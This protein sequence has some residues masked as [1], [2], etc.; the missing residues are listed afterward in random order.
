MARKTNKNSETEKYCIHLT[1]PPKKG[2]IY[3]FDTNN[4]YRCDITEKFCIAKYD[5]SREFHDS[6]SMWGY[7]Y[8]CI[9]ES[10]LKKCPLHNISE[11]I[12]KAIKEDKI[13]RE[14]SELEKKLSKV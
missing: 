3:K 4:C 1:N 8:P 5:E 12:A 2:V 9:E 6:H 13:K 7:H 11:K 14:I 10:N